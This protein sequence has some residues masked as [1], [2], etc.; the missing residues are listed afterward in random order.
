[1]GW[2]DVLILSII[3]SIS[4]QNF[5]LSSNDHVLRVRVDGHN[6]SLL[7]DNALLV[8]NALLSPNISWAYMG[9]YA[10]IWIYMGI[11][12]HIWAYML[13]NDHVL[14]M[15]VD[16]HNRSLLMNNALLVKN[17]LLSPNISWAYTCVKE[18]NTNQLKIQLLG[19]CKYAL[20]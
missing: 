13:S 18:K 14:R 16:G 6:R 20:L 12:G 11:Y 8:K 15:C 9:I 7:I 3:I 1:M 2:F 10:H 17:A 5:L 4:I 19:Y